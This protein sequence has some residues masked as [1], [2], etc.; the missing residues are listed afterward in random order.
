MSGDF[1]KFMF[2]SFIMMD[3][4][5]LLIAYGNYIH[6]NIPSAIG[7]VIGFIVVLLPEYIVMIK[8]EE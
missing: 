7:W 3:V 8:G 1:R 5:A 2:A 4:L 6:G